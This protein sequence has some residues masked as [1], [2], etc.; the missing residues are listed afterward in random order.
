MK[1]QKEKNSLNQ[2]TWLQIFWKRVG[3]DFARR[4][5]NGV[6]KKDMLKRKM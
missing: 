5:R 3:S 1:K 2:L 6:E 4:Q